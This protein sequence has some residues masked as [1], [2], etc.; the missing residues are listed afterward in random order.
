[1]LTPLVL[2]W[3]SHLWFKSHRGEMHDDSVVFALRD[4][5]SLGLGFGAAVII[6]LATP[7]LPR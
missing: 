3:V 7:C 6:L 5:V 4:C 1:L 2:Y